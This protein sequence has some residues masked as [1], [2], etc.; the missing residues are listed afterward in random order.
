MGICLYSGTDCGVG[1]TLIGNTSYEGNIATLI[2]SNNVQI[3]F[4]APGMYQINLRVKYLANY[5]PTGCQAFSDATMGSP[6]FKFATSKVVVNVGSI[7]PNFIQYDASTMTQSLVYLYFSLKCP[8]L[9][10]STV[11]CVVSLGAPWITDPQLLIRL[12]GANAQIVG[13]VPF[14]LCVF[15]NSPAIKFDVR[16]DVCG[17]SSRGVPPALTKN[18]QI[19]FNSSLKVTF[20]NYFNKGATQMGIQLDQPLANEVDYMIPA[21]LSPTINASLSISTPLS[22]KFGDYASVTITST[23]KFSGICKI[24]RYELADVLMATTALKSGKAQVKVHWLWASNS[25]ASPMTMKVVCSGGGKYATKQI[26]LTG[27]RN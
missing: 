13:K 22:V 17:D 1:N 26:L 2:G 9:S 25:S 15:T 23:P 8:D 4:K 19:L 12:Y 18:L 27:Y 21:A 10:G 24:Y 11:T 20:P 16:N 5:L 14:Q 7:G 3:K 6:C